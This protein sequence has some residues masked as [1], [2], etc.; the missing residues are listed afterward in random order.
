MY[1]DEETCTSVVKNKFFK[2]LKYVREKGCPLDDET[3]IT[4][5]EYGFID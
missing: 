3:R 4:V 1:M 5:L 2:C